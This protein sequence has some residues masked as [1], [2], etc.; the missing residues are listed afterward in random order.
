MNNY[1]TCLAYLYKQ[2]P[3]F[4]RK[5]AAAYK[6]NLENTIALDEMFQHPHQS[7]KTIHIGGTN[8]KGS[9]SHMLAS[10][11]QESGYKV[12]L[13]TSPHLIDFRE[14]IRI[15]GEMITRSAVVN[16]INSY[17]E[18]NKK[19]KVEPSFFELTVMMA[20]QYFKEQKV[21]VAI[22]EVGLGGRLDST[23]IIQ[24]ELALITN[25]SLDHTNLLGNS[26]ES[27]AREKAGIIKPGIPIVISESN[28]GYNHVFA[29]KAKELQSPI[30]FADRLHLPSYELDLKGICQQR[31]IRGVLQSIHLLQHDGWEVQEIH[32]KQGLSKVCQNTKLRGRWE[33]VQ[34]HPMVI[35]DTGHN[36]AGIHQIATQIAQTPKNNLWIVIGMVTDKDQKKVLSLLPKKANYIFTQPGIERAISASDLAKL[37][38]TIGLKG[39][40]IPIVKEAAQ[41]AISRANIDDLVFIGGSTFVV[42]DYFS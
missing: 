16:F 21:D 33:I 28:E 22:V 13:Y 1:D 6:A 20:F 4:Q 24:P 23:N 35:C 38:S 40:V 7:F 41:Y 42:A 27:I 31:N 9:T 8:G 34:Q 19:V 3:M 10:I 25:I 30:Y 15:N 37:A 26:I 36:E 32:I 5:G 18:L 17:I 11:L 12:G 29:D 2:L 39:R 14:R